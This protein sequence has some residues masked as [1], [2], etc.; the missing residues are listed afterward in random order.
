MTVNIDIKREDLCLIAGAYHLDVEECDNGCCRILPNNE[1]VERILLH[2]K[3]KIDGGK[4]RKEN[5]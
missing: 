1:L 2:L 5:I 3:E 4:D